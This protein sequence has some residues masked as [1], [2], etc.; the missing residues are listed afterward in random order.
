MDKI[1]TPEEA[2]RLLAVSPKT[3]R[4]WIRQGKLKES[5]AGRLLRIR[6]RDLE[7]FLDPA[8]Y[9]QETTKKG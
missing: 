2:A 7:A 4:K 5:R 8:R 9:A 6:E 1:F 3:I